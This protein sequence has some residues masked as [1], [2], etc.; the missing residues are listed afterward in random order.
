MRSELEERYRRLIQL[1]DRKSRF[2]TS[3]IEIYQDDGR[4]WMAA[5]DVAYKM[6]T[7]K[8]KRIINDSLKD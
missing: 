2:W 1:W 6:K 7:E 8:F 5:F 3:Q 4:K